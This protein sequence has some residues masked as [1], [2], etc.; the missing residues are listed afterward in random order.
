MKESNP[1]GAGAKK[2]YKTGTVVKRIH[3]I[4]PVVCQD[5]ILKSIEEITKP[6]K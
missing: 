2:K 4:I 5:D 6:Y 3:P 1:K